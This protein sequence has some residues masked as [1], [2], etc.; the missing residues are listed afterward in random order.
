MADPQEPFADVV[1]VEGG[2]SIPELKWRELLFVGAL[3]PEGDAFVRDP[4]R[5]LP[6]FRR[7]GLFPEGVLFR[8]ERAGGRVVVRRVARGARDRPDL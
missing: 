4:A 6:P 1:P 3:R 7:E 8:A 2:F 5:P